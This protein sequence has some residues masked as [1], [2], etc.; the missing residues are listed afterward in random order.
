[1]ERWETRKSGSLPFI[2]G[3][4]GW[5]KEIFDTSIM[6]FKTSS[7]KL[8]ESAYFRAMKSRCFS[9]STIGRIE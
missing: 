4:L 7:K 3:G 8:T 9:Y 6:T 5:G 2:R 1:L